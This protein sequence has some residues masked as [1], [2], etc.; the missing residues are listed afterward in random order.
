MLLLAT[1]SSEDRPIPVRDIARELDIPSASLAKTV[2]ILTRAGLLSSQRGPGGGLTL[3]RPATE[4][5]L[6][7]VVQ[8]IEGGGLQRE[9][10]IGI[11]GCSEDMAHCPFHDQWGKIRRDVLKMLGAQNI[12]QVAK[13]VK[14]EKH[15]LSRIAGEHAG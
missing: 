3:G 11:P 6:L 4:L 7:D 14:R 13:R 12:A 2:Q 15:V 5:T 1:H 10:V 9:C 8:S